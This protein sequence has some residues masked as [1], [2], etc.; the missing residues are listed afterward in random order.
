MNASSLTATIREGGF[1]LSAWSTMPGAALVEA[2]A[3]GPFD[4]VTIDMQH[5][6]HDLASTS[7]AISAVALAGKGAA[8]RLALHAWG[9]A[10]RVLDAG[11]TIVIAPMID[12]PELARE[13]VAATKYLPLGARSW[14][15]QRAMA[16]TGLGRAAY[17]ATANRL[18]LSLAMIE[19]REG[20]ERLDEILAVDGIDGV[21]VGP[22]DLSIALSDGA[23]LDPGSGEVDAALVHVAAR[24]AHHGKIAALFAVSPEMAIRARDLGYRFVAL[25]TDSSYLA[26]G[27]AALVDAVRP[28]D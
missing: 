9:D 18:C 3:R 1:A 25:S 24:A 20:L 23:A 22:S 17:L 12:T 4:C 6:G 8:V 11:A 19:T 28:A 5:G 15:P 14:G 7:A 10:S 13:F 26:M 27:M 21:F 16:L 2:I